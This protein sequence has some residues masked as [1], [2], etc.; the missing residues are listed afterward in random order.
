MNEKFSQEAK[1]DNKRK[2]KKLKEEREIKQLE[3]SRK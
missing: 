2:M 1:L 3:K